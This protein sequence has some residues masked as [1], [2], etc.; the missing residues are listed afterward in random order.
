MLMV[1]HHQTCSAHLA[2]FG[3]WACHTCAFLE[4]S[5]I[6]SAGPFSPVL[7]QLP[8]R[9]AWANSL[10]Y[11]VSITAGWVATSVKVHFKELPKPNET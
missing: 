4:L 2:P 7:V 9:T 5:H 8:Q 1:R 6:P 11:Q 10:P 3:H